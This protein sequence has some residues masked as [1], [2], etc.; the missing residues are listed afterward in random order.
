MHICTIIAKN[1]LAQARVLSESFRRHHPDGRV[2]V[3][4]ID[5]IGERFD[6]AAEPFDVLTPAELEIETFER[7]AG[8]YDVMEL[9]TAV[10]PWLLRHLLGESE[11][12]TY[13][14]PDIEVF[15]ELTELVDLARRHGLVL[16]PHYTAPPPD[17]GRKPSEGDILRAGVYNLGFVA[18]GRGPDTDRL[19]D[20]WSDRLRTECYVDFAADRFVDQR[21]MDM[22]PAMVSQFHV[23]RD[24]GYNVA[25]WNLH[26]RRLEREDGACLV[27]GRPLRFFHFS[28]Y[29]PELPDRL[30]PPFQDRFELTR[31]PVVREL[32][33]AYSRQL[34]RHGYEEAKAWSY[35]YDALPNGIRLDSEL[36][37]LFREAVQRQELD[38]SIFTPTGAENFV[39][40]LNGTRVPWGVNVLGYFSAELG[41]GEAGRQMVEA[42]GARGIPN[43]A[44]RQTETSNRQEHEFEAAD[45]LEARYP[46]NLLCVNADALLHLGSRMDPEFF[47]GRYSIGLW[48]WEV[49][50]F[51]ER[52]LR[53]FDYVDEVWV[54]S[55][56]V[57]DAVASV[58]PVPVTPITLPVSPLAPAPLDRAALGLPTEGLLF[59]SVFDYMS[60]FERKNPLAS[61]EA[62]RR[63][64]E[65]GSGA[66]LVIK[67][68]NSD[69][70][71][72]NR[73]LLE[74]AV[75]G[76]PD[77]H[78]VDRY[79]S[80][81]E[82]N[83]ML[84][85]CDCY[86]SLHRSEGFGLP[87]AEAM[88]FG[89]P[90]IG[91]AYSGNLEFM[92]EENSYL[93][94]A[95]LRRIDDGAQFYSGG[96]HWAEPDV[97]RAAS[98]MRKVL[99]RPQAARERGA[100]AAA[101]IR[102]SHSPQ[103]AGRV[104]ERRL[105]E[106]R[107][108]ATRRAL[109]EQQRRGDEGPSTPEEVA[110]D[111]VAAGPPQQ[112]SPRLGPVGGTARKAMLRL[113]KPYTAH[114]QEVDRITLAAVSE[115]RAAV[116]GLRDR[117]EPALRLADEARAL[118]YMSDSPFEL[119]DHPVGGRVSGYF[120]GGAPSSAEGYRDFE[121]IFRGPEEMIRDRQRPYLELLAGREPVLDAGCGRGEFL[122][123]LREAGF[124][125]EGV[126]AD[127]DM[128]RRCHA[129]GHE[130]VRN[131]DLNAY[132][133]SLAPA[134]LGAI[135]SAQVIEHL[136]YRELRR[137]L[138]LAREKLLPGGMF[139]A[140]TVNPHSPQALK[141]FWVD[142][143]HQ[144]PIF[145]EVALE[146]CRISG[147]A[148]AFVFHPVGS[149]DVEVDRYRCGEYAVVATVDDGRA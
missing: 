110:L 5:E 127:P 64:F 32:C 97:E 79:A 125:Y 1:Y 38:G 40:W 60:S 132:L 52:W 98:L 112:E 147:Y 101:D 3:L 69:R 105:A 119:R 56:H 141:T 24:P 71:P 109:A 106:L 137:F 114:E 133:D 100:R 42:L 62:F 26:E 50:R 138:A 104:I 33:D 36:R 131:A 129:K 76:H 107:P 2:S 77:I 63:A 14:D 39:T 49:T 108:E 61:V 116:E 37:A 31:L 8:I 113:M 11:A 88:Y 4:V 111:R 130:R 91:T 53:A 148:S 135:F 34:R 84:A 122:D 58:A 75:A 9:S 30:S 19:L 35:G 46:V 25:Y 115:L 18:V 10:K 126:D 20:W 55:R 142:L 57:A 78:L 29:K 94:P 102:R 85:A 68:I 13:L 23:V 72:G 99:E 67:S 15:A 139:I 96:G 22:A 66:K 140:E 93:V 43:L 146:L 44:I 145:P 51:P 90:V 117:L 124:D 149:G 16:T 87:L 28:G 95:E 59:L 144:H 45:E 134:S 74:G 81:A 120:G 121:E 27:E 83:A 7:M 70:D 89:K 47:A 103:A 65:P 92:T 86:L 128:V 80:P 54:G 21:W 48:W 136:S 12:I 143:T 82:K 17:D 118:P 123:L 41:V 6:P 73:A